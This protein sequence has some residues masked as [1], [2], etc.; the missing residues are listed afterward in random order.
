M[1]S[2]RSLR[3]Q[4]NGSAPAVMTLALCVVLSAIVLF[5]RLLDFAPADTQHYIPL[6]RSGGATTVTVGYRDARGGIRFAGYNPRNHRLLTAN[7]GM[8][9]YDA[10]T[11]W[12]SQTDIELFKI[13]YENGAKQ[14][15]VN[16]SDGKKVIAPGTANTYKF[17]LENTGNV[18]LEFT[19]TMKA[20]FTCKSDPDLVIPVL[21]RV[22]DYKGNYLAGSAK[23]KAPALELNKVTQQG[24]LTAGYVAPYTLEWEWPFEGDDTFDTLLGNMAVEEEI[25]LTVEIN[26]I[27]TQAEDSPGSTK[28]GS[29][30]P[31]ETTP[32][33]S[34]SGNSSSGTSKPTVNGGLPKTGDTSNIR[35]A[36]TVMIASGIG[37]LILMALSQRKGRKKHET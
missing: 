15:T 30:E 28:P 7:P 2:Y 29:T 37:L 5:S 4:N 36:F 16:S 23:A 12:K 25:S 24:T 21:A 34:S 14:V 13:S 3:K 27:S 10:N 33:G 35:L 26:V 31:G 11:V 20:W 19:M 22:R 6:T 8:K 18:P 9:V 32:G 17:T 1:N